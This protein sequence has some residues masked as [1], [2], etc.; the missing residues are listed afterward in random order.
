MLSKEDAK[1]LGIE[2]Y[3]LDTVR[4]CLDKLQEECGE[5]IQAVSKHRLDPK[6]IPYKSEGRTKT[7][8]RLLLDELGDVRILIDRVLK[9]EKDELNGL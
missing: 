1:E 5:L 7:T 6:C 9:F 2:I 4:G 3:D 8:T